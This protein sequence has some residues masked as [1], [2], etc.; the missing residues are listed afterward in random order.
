[1]LYEISKESFKQRL[2]DRLNFKMVD[3]TDYSKSS[4]EKF[5][6][7]LPIPFTNN[8]VSEVKGKGIGPLNNLII[9]S[10]DKHSKDAKKA[11]DALKAEGFQFIYYYI[12]SV[13]DLILEKGLN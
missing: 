6:D 2:E 12:G 5:K 3:V 9:F 8:F 10:L 4:H 13:E 11:A 1:M 7:V